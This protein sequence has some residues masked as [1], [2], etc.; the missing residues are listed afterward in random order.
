MPWRNSQKSIREVHFPYKYIF[1]PVS[2]LGRHHVEQWKGRTQE[3]LS[4]RQ[5]GQNQHAMPRP[6]IA[7][8]LTH[9]PELPLV[10]YQMPARSGE[11]SVRLI[12]S[13]FAYRLKSSPGFGLCSSTLGS[14]AFLTTISAI[15][16]SFCSGRLLRRA[17]VRSLAH[18][19]ARN[20]LFPGSHASPINPFD[21]PL[22]IS[23]EKSRLG[24]V[25]LTCDAAHGVARD[26]EFLVRRDHERL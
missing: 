2:F 18:T 26:Q 20:A 16:Q 9:G 3:F 15:R 23:C 6:D 14:P 8:E 21:Q 7:P 4:Q 25:W 10:F 17:L 12:H 24:R 5:R 1:K 19:V 22:Q 13:P 11:I